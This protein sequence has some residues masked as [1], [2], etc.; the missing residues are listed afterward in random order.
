ML[1]VQESREFKSLSLRESDFTC[2]LRK[3]SDRLISFN[4]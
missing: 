1:G 4:F 3:E 2:G